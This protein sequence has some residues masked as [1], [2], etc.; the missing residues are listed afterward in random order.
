[1]TEFLFDP[2]KIHS[3]SV[4]GETARYPVHRIFCVGRNYAAHAEE[5]GERADRAAP[6]YFTK[7]ASAVLAGG[8]TLAYPPGTTNFHHEMELVVAIGA[9][10]FRANREQALAAIYAF[11]CG[12]DMTRR[13]LQAAARS[14]QQPWDLAKDIEG[15]AVFG[16]LTK[17]AEVGEIGKQRIYLEVN[18]QVRQDAYL[19]ELIHKVDDIV[20]DLSNYYHLAPGDL[21]MTGTPAGVGPVVPGDELRGGIEGLDDIRLDIGPPENG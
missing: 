9:K 19:S 4:L 15:G 17:A 7:S 8:A 14:K 1:M 10:A 21:I 12:L 13:D 6:F 16:S 2:P 20:M 18:G 11:G 3:L 5:M